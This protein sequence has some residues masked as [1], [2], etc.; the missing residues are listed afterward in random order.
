MAFPVGG[1]GRVCP[2]VVHA[3]IIA[4]AGVSGSDLIIDVFGQQNLTDA[5]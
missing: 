5:A 1:Y 2:G 3:V 4:C